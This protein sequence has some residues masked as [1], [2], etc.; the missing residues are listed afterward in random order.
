M[1]GSPWVPLSESLNTMS[2]IFTSQAAMD[3]GTGCA[4]AKFG[5][6]FREYSLGHRL[7]IVCLL[8]PRISVKQV[9]NVIATLGFHYSRRVEAIGFLGEPSFTWHRGGTFERL[10]RALANDVWVSAFPNCSVAHLLRLKSD[11]WPLL[12][13]MRSEFNV[14][15]GRPFRFLAG[16]TKHQNF[17]TFVKGKWSYSGNMAESLSH[18]TSCIKDWDISI[19]DILVLRRSN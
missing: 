18:F 11:H 3:V 13:S 6:V 2:E 17:A 12:L 9:D 14:A 10:D 19:M 1:S 7:D 8:E 5:R 16:W 15:Q 4:S